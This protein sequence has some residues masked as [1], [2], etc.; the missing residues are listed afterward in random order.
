MRNQPNG[1]RN[2]I[3]GLP[4]MYGIRERMVGLGT[5]WGGALLQAEGTNLPLRG[6]T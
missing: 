2:V 1:N 6:S 3:V 4:R 5:F